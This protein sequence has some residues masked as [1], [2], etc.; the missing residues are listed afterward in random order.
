MGYTEF[1]WNHHKALINARKH[2][3]SF[4][5]AK[6]LF[7]RPHLA[8]MDTR[9]VYGEERWIAIGWID[10]MVAVVAYTESHS[11]TGIRTIRI[12]SAR[13]ASNSE[14]ARYEQEFRN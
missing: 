10:E 8:A 4:E 2:G 3:V 1:E 11:G 13:K 5:I 7:D 14:R 6:T 12:I 9:Y